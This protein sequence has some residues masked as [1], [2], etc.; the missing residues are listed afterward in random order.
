MAGLGSVDPQLQH[1]I[2]VETQKQRFQQ[3]V[4][5]MTELCWKKCVDKP[6]PK[7]DSRPEACF[8]NCASLIQ[9]SSGGRIIWYLT[10]R[11]PYL[12]F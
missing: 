2:E 11:P 3:L 6:G 4:H 5:P 1:S 8:V 12:V 10:C 9:G 7:L